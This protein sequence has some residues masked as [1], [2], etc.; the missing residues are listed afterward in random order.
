MRERAGKWISTTRAGWLG[1]QTYSKRIGVPHHL[2][3]FLCPAVACFLAIIT[4][5]IHM[6]HATCQI[7]CPLRRELCSFARS[8]S[9]ARSRSRS[10]LRSRLVV[11]PAACHSTLPK[12]WRIFPLSTPENVCNFF[13]PTSPMLR[14]LEKLSPVEK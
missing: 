5:F 13:T 9:R 7:C 8:P 12:L 3:L 10:R 4:K 14:E 6:P 11:V 1:R 2:F